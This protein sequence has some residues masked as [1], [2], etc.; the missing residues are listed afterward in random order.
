MQVRDLADDA[1]P[2]PCSDDLANRAVRIQVVLAEKTAVELGTDPAALVAHADDDVAAVR[3]ALDDDPAAVWR[4]LHRIV[5]QLVESLSQLLGVAG[6]RRDRAV[7]VDLD[8][9]AVDSFS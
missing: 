5:Q 3:G 9:D 2:Q 1:E 4:E 8:R 7:Q 6:H